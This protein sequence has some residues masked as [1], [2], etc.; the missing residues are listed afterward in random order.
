MRNVVRDMGIN[1]RWTGGQ[2]IAIPCL[3]GRSLLAARWGHGRGWLAVAL[4]SM[5]E[6]GIIAN[7]ALAYSI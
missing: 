6:V 1:T 7:L 4:I 5:A 3:G 2:S